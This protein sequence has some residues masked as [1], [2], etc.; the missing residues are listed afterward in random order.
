MPHG[1]DQDNSGLPLGERLKQARLKAGLTQKDLAD[2]D[3]TASYISQVERGVIT[4]SVKALGRLA[5]RLGQSLSDFFQEE[6][7]RPDRVEIE[8]SLTQAQL[9]IDRGLWEEADGHLDRAA[10]LSRDTGEADLEIRALL[11]RADLDRRQNLIM[12]AVSRITAALERASRHGLDNLARSCCH[13]LGQLYLSQ[14]N[15]L[16]AVQYLKRASQIGGE[17]ETCPHIL[18]SL[19]SGYLELGEERLA[20]EFLQQAVQAFRRRSGWNREI[21]R[22]RGQSSALWQEGRRDDALD[23]AKG[24]LTLSGYRRSQSFFSS[25]LR[26]QAAS[27]EKSE[28]YS[29]A[30]EMLLEA[31]NLSQRA[32]DAREQVDAR[33][34]LAEMLLSQGELEQAR[35]QARRARQA[36]E[37]LEDTE[38]AQVQHLLGNI[39]SRRGRPDSALAHWRESL[40]LYRR[41]GCSQQASQVC[42]DIGELSLSEGNRDEALRYFR[43]AADLR[44]DS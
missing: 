2:A 27:V 37:D 36:A 34:Q 23:A 38:M 6:Q 30:R 39:E 26:H 9:L 25:L 32:D 40:G 12:E 8:F 7:G 22:L 31:L 4:P 29:R 16:M 28:E 19:S 14:D 1:E 44:R 3:F 17:P 20:E 24:A 42:A 35:A 11:T 18:A 21:D 10:K 33:R 13:Q 15:P 41:A 43:M 5:G